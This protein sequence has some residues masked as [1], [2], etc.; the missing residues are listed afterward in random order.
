MFTGIVRARGKVDSIIR[1]GDDLRIRIRSADL[2][3]ADYET[4]DSIAVNGVCLTAVGLDD[5]Y[6]EA[7][8]STETLRVTALNS[9][10]VGSEVNLEPALAVGQPLGGHIVSG[11]VD[12]VG[13]LVGRE[14]EARSVRLDFEIP[15]EFSRYVAR[16]GS[17][18]V[19]GVSLTVNDVTGSS[20]SVNIIPHTAD[21]TIVG[22]Y[23]VGSLVNVEVDL[24]ARYIERLIDRGDTGLTMEFLR[25]NGYV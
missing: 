6:F 13:K 25:A 14:V 1:H 11:H 18:T 4:G 3:F 12:C 19:D 7:D 8:V 2:P 22:S 16:K 20:F 24:L 23:R 9:L 10:D 17:I 5:H 15:A 21:V